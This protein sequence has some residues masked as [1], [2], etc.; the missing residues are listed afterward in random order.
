MS[1][2]LFAKSIRKSGVVQLMMNNNVN[3]SFCLP[4][5][6]YKIVDKFEQ[7]YFV[8]VIFDAIKYLK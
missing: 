2:K 5:L 8:E 1:E 7:F 3:L 6:A 4:H